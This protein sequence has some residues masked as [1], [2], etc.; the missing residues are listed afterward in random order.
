LSDSEMEKILSFISTNFDLL[1][2]FANEKVN[3]ADFVKSI[4]KFDESVL[5]I[6]D[7]RKLK[8]D[9]KNENAT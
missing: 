7:N 1:Y 3:V 5:K 2:D 4:N 8:T 9:N 6:T